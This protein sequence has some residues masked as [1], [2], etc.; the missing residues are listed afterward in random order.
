M[1]TKRMLK[2]V[3][4]VAVMFSAASTSYA[5]SERLIMAMSA[6][7]MNQEN[8]VYVKFIGPDGAAL[9]SDVLKHMV[10]REQDCN[11]GRVF[12]MVTDYK[13]GYAPKNMLVGIYLFPHTWNNKSLCFNVPN[14]G[15]IEQSLD[16]ASNKGRIF[17][18]KL[19]P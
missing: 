4:T 2:V 5:G 16:T 14:L 18:L 3:L 19:A 8:L 1:N 15:K 11:S 17:Q 10:I 7:R 6:A 12:E 13:I 9:E